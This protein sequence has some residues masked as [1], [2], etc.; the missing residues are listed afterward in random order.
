[1]T[2]SGARS[3]NPPARLQ[4]W[5]LHAA[6]TGCKHRLQAKAASTGRRHKLQAQAAA[7][8]C[9]AAGC[10]HNCNHR[11]QAQFA[12][13][14]CTQGCTRMQDGPTH[15]YQIRI[16]KS[17]RLQ[18]RG[19]RAASVVYGLGGR[20]ARRVRAGAASSLYALIPRSGRSE[21]RPAS[22]RPVNQ[23]PASYPWSKSDT[24]AAKSDAVTGAPA[25]RGSVTFRAGWPE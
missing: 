16:R 18:P 19:S 13:T 2:S 9:S 22:S 20:L 15:E 21:G 23:R 17:P 7:T 4:P 8:D 24:G 14:G 5:V 10:N 25:S 1:M 6:S 12:T 3:D 11:L